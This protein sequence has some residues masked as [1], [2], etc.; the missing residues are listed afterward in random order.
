M[1]NLDKGPSDVGTD[2]GYSVPKNWGQY[3]YPALREASQGE[4]KAQVAWLG[5]SE[6]QGYYASDLDATSS[7]ALVRDAVQEFGGNGGSGFRGM[8]FSDTFLSG[9][10]SGAY[11]RYK[12][13]GNAWVHTLNGGSISTPTFEFGPSSGRLDIAGGA[14]VDIPFNGARLALWFFNSHGTSPFTYAVDGGSAV[15]VTPGPSMGGDIAMIRLLSPTDYGEGDHVVRITSGT[16]PIYFCGIDAENDAGVVF[17]NYAIAGLESVRYSNADGFESGTYMG[18]HR[19][20][21][22]YGDTPTEATPDLLIIGVPPNDAIKVINTFSMTTTSGSANVTGLGFRMGDE[23]KTISGAGIPAGTTI[24]AVN[25]GA[26]ATMSAN[27]TVSSTADRSLTATDAVD[28]FYKNWE[29]YLAGVLDNVYGG[30]DGV[31]GRTDVLVVD[32]MLKISSDTV[33]PTWRRIQSAAQS[34]AGLYGA[35]YL[36]VGATLNQSWSR[37]YNNHY[38][39]NPNDPTSWSDDAI[40]MSDAGHLY[41]AEKI[42]RVI[43]R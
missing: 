41:T 26:S 35:A 37:F 40:H 23:G 43:L 3:W 11:N 4:R 33:R 13:Q 32:P 9:A 18:G 31:E 22:T 14:T 10:P 28:R 39:G 20:R 36:N 34:M 17:N 42:L 7:F 29:Q 15:T 2:I 12:D 1:V 21:N 25:Q 30:G 24:T 19:F 6:M 8:Q 16:N 5:S 38:M 27:A